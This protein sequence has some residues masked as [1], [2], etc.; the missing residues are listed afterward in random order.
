MYVEPLLLIQILSTQKMSSS[1][2]FSKYVCVSETGG[3]FIIAISASFCLVIFALNSPC[4]H[5][6][7]EGRGGVNS[8]ISTLKT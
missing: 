3:H 8:N 7:C 5:G 4:D 6:H 1:P 2:T